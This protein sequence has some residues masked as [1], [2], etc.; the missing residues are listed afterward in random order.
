M[1]SDDLSDNYYSMSEPEDV[2]KIALYI[3]DSSGNVEDVIIDIDE[4]I[5]YVTALHE[6][7]PTAD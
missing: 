2:K 1:Y 3:L 4:I 7:Y 5:Q 6:K